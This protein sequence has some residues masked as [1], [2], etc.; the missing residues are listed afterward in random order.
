[1]AV[2]P[3]ALGT[4]AGVD[5]ARRDL[6]LFREDIFELVLTER[7]MRELYD[8]IDRLIEE[9]GYESAH[10]FDPSRVLF[11]TNMTM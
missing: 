8:A 4:N 3:T 9:L 10:F 1:M 6:A 7:S 11:S 2:S 5:R